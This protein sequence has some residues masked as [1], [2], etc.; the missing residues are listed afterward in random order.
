M[1]MELAK[2]FDEAL[3]RAFELQ[4]ADVKSNSYP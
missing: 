2:T 4:G 1:H 3:A